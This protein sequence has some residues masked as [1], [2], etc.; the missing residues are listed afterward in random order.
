MARRRGP[1]RAQ[2][3]S[4]I[5]PGEVGSACWGLAAKRQP[6]DRL[7]PGARTQRELLRAVEEPIGARRNRRFAGD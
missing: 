4:A 6:S 7:L 5:R 2:R 1:T 3:S